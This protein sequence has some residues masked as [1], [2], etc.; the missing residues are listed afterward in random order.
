MSELDTKSADQIQRDNM[1]TLRR[2]LWRRGKS[3]ASWSKS[4]L[5]EIRADRAFRK[6][7]PVEAFGTLN[8]YWPDQEERR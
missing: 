8:P 4:D 5:D 7:K 6:M 1:R 3:I 2:E